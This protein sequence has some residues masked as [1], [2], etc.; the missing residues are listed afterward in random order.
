MTEE[1]RKVGTIDMTPTWKGL[2]PFF[3]LAIETGTPEGRKVAIEE[4]TRMAGIADEYV[5]LVKKSN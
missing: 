2:V 5:S 1:K 4:L 3:V